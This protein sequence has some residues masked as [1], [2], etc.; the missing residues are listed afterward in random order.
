[1]GFW[2]CADEDIKGYHPSEA[3]PDY[4]GA[5]FDVEAGDVLAFGGYTS[6]LAEKKFDPLRPPV[7]S[8]MSIMEGNHHEGPI[9]ID[10]ESEKITIVL[11]KAD[12]RNYTDVRGQKLAGVYF[13]MGRF[14]STSESH[15]E[16]RDIDRGILTV[17][18]E[19]FIFSGNMKTINI[20]LRK[21]LQV[22]PF[23]DGLALHKEGREKTQYFVWNENIGRM[24]LSEGDRK[25]VEPIN[26]MIVKCVMEGAIRNYSKRRRG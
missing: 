5:S 20:D 15:Q 25:Y 17:T 10:Y 16:I 24:Q 7:S 12:W 3:H 9:Q 19:R 4:A 13:R 8:F 2:I 21:I 22:D 14:G 26:G 18:G 1:M 11:S 6:F 23:T